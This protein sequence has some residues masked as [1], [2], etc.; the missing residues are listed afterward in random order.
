MSVKNPT[1]LNYDKETHQLYY[2]RG[3]SYYPI[4]S[5]ELPDV[6]GGGTAIT[7]TSYASNADAVAALGV[8]KMYKSTTLINGSPIILY[9]V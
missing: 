6:A 3:R 5:T 1:H 9:T 8:G 2:K 4:T 7:E